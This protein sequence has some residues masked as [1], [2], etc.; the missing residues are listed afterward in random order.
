MTSTDARVRVEHGRLATG[1]R[2]DWRTNPAILARV[3]RIAPIAV[4]PCASDDPAHHFALVNYTTA[5]DGLAQSWTDARGLAFVNNPYSRCRDF[6]AKAAYEASLGVAVVLLVPARPGA[7][8]YRL[9]RRHAD[10]IAELHGRQTFIG[11]ESTAPFPSAI[12][13]MN[14]SW[15]RVARAFDDIADIQ[16]PTTLAPDVPA[17]R[18]RPATPR[19][20]TQLLSLFSSPASEEGAM[21]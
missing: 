13:A 18:P 17:V 12:I 7:K 8:W 16:I 2:D 14:L 9:A 5:D 1:G 15:R 3:A 19:R 21:P 6:I 10:C 11:A 20:A 4:D